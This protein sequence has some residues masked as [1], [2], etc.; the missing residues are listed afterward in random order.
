MASQQAQEILDKAT[1]EANELRMYA[2]QYTE[3]RRFL[4]AD[5]LLIALDFI[6][7]FHP[8]LP[9]QLV[10]IVLNC[11]SPRPTASF[12]KEGWTPCF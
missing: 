5:D 2:A 8:Q 9:D 1:I 12:P 3:D 4:I 11:R 7:S 10:Y 6:G